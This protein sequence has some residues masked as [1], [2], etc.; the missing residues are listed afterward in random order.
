MMA[1]PTLPEG[2]LWDSVR[3]YWD[4]FRLTIIPSVDYLG[5]IPGDI[6]VA[7]TVIAPAGGAEAARQSV[8][9]KYPNVKVDVIVGGNVEMIQNALELRVEQQREYG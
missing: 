9:G 2:W 6:T 5:L 3:E 8:L 1:A 4:R 7:L